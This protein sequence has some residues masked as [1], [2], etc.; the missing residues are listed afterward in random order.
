MSRQQETTARTADA[1]PRAM[2]TQCALDAAILRPPAPRS[3]IRR[4]PRP[5]GSRS[6]HH[7]RLL[8]RQTPGRTAAHPLRPM[9]GI[10]HRLE[11][12]P[13]ADERVR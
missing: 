2:G 6:R 10:R 8:A 9:G 12:H 4:D 3:G 13:L 11:L 7:Y 1:I 5:A